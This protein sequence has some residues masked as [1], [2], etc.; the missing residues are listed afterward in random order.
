MGRLNLNA[1]LLWPLLAALV[2][3]LRALEAGDAEEIRK[4]A[5]RTAS[6]GTEGQICGLV[7]LAR[8][9]PSLKS[10]SD[11]VRKQKVQ[12]LHCVKQLVAHTH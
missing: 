10:L 11:G 3:G 8:R 7:L 4:A 6:G 9:P 2:G 12:V 5:H 1:L